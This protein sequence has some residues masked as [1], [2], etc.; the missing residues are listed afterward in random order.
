MSN[1]ADPVVAA[2]VVRF[3]EQHIPSVP[4]LEAL[5]LMWES[6]PRAWAERELAARIYV[7]QDT[8]R[9]ILREFESAG[10]VVLQQSSTANFIYNHSTERGSVVAELAQAYRRQLSRIA[11]LIHRR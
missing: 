10:L 3:I 7:S 2:D 11:S 5:L 1:E 4:H 6:T 9:R 8:A